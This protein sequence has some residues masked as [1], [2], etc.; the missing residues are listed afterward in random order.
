VTITLVLKTKIPAQEDQAFRA[1]TRKGSVIYAIGDIHGR[2][3]LLRELHTAILADAHLREAKRRVIVYL[4][5][6][7]CRGSGSRA[8]LDIL[9][10]NPLPGFEA[11]FLRGNHEDIICRFLDGDL[12]WGAHWLEYGGIEALADYGVI[13]NTMENREVH[14]LAK[15]RQDFIVAL[16]KEHEQFMRS[17]LYSHREDD[18]LFV[19]AGIK[20]GIPL[21]NTDPDTFMWIRREFLSS[22]KNHGAIVVHGHTISDEPDVRLNR[23]GIDTGAYR[24][25]ILTCLVLEGAERWFLQTESK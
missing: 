9:C 24:S 2:A 11:I 25:G 19:H 3:D 21:E 13:T 4:G 1:V 20:P 7:T 12:S 17:T 22:K 23:I 5:D 10:Q 8:V 15:L 6:Y 14:K 18:Y 16:P